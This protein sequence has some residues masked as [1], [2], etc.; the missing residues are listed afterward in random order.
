[1]HQLIRVLVWAHDADD[2]RASA[3]SLVTADGALVRGHEPFDYGT[4]LDEGGRWADHYDLAAEQGAV[5]ADSDDGQELIEQGWEFTEES[6]NENLDMLRELLDEH[7]NE[8]LMTRDW[9]DLSDDHRFDAKNPQYLLWKLGAYE[10][11]GVYLYTH[12]GE[13]IQTRE[14]FES[15]RNGEYAEDDDQLFVVPIDVHR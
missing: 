10:G 12:S 14:R 3:K 1:M 6:W 5:P 13:G 9:L 8:E 4:L 7:S 11:P 2:A 15:V